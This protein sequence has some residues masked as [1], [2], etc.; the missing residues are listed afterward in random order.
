MPRK[1]KP[2]EEFR[3]SK[4]ASRCGQAERRI[5][6]HAD[7]L[8]ATYIRE[9]RF[10]E[11]QISLRNSQYRPSERLDGREATQEHPAYP[12]VWYQIAETLLSEGIDPADYVHRIFQASIGRTLSPPMVKELLTDKMRESFEEAYQ[13]I[14]EQVAWALQ[15]EHSIASVEIIGYQEYG[16]CSM[17]K[18]TWLT[19]CDGLLDLS[20][21]YRYCLARS[22]KKKRFTQLARNQFEDS[23]ILQFMAARE[24]YRVSWKDVLPAGFDDRAQKRYA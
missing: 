5:R 9:R 14:K 12:D 6:Q 2:G 24:A 20:D 16:G 23:A 4:Q 8:K 15:H 22:M 10:Y 18:A 19:L 11:S 3:P 21:L 17:L 13:Y 1:R 7:R